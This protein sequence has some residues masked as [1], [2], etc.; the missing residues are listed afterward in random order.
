M[1]PLYCYF[2]PPLFAGA[3]QRSFATGL[4]HRRELVLVFVP[5]QTARPRVTSRSQ[6]KVS[7]VV[8]LPLSQVAL[9]H[10][11]A[12]R[13]QGHHKGAG[14]RDQRG[15]ALAGAEE[16][17]NHLGRRRWLHPKVLPRL[18]LHLVGDDPGGRTQRGRPCLGGA[19]GRRGALAGGGAVV[20]SIFIHFKLKIFQMHTFFTNFAL[21]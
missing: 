9:F 4:L 21:Y 15:G 3:K 5:F 12:S 17:L 18:L 19:A 2:H 20:L 6:D 7:C 16:F 13:P 10:H 1:S 11:V 8:A 14:Q